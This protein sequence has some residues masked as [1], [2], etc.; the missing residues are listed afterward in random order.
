MSQSLDN[1][2]Q[3][4]SKWVTENGIYPIKYSCLSCN[5]I[6]N[7]DTKFLHTATLEEIEDLINKFSSYVIYLK[8]V[9]SSIEVQIQIIDS[10]LNNDIFKIV[11][12]LGSDYQYKSIGEKISTIKS[13]Y[14]EIDKRSFELNILKAKLLKIKDMPYSIEKKIDIFKMI[15]NR[16]IIEI[17]K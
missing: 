5:D 9:K 15:Y 6:I 13:M 16:R 3:K 12:S 1:F 14:P 17:K 7:I 10:E 11:S 4:I 2:T 8:S